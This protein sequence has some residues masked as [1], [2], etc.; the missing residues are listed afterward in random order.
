MPIAPE[1]EAAMRSAAKRT[2]MEVEAEVIKEMLSKEI[3]TRIG[4]G[5]C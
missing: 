3:V 5:D 1:V 2:D 4:K